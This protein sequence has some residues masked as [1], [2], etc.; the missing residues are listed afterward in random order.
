MRQYAQL[1]RPSQWTKNGFVLVGVLFGHAW[2][3]PAALGGAFVLFASFCLLSAAVYALNDVMDREADRAHPAKRLRPLPSGRVSVRGALVFGAACA[4]S[5]LLLA[6]LV[7][8]AALA[9][10]AG[11]LVLNAAYS[12]GLKHVAV[13]DVF[14]IAAGFML[15][16]L[17]GTSGIGIAP[18]RWLLLCGL[19]AT[20]FLGFAKRRAELAELRRRDPEDRGAQRRA[21]ENYS[22]ELLDRM[23]AVSA[24]GALISYALY[25]VDARTAEVQGTDQLVLTVPFVLYGLYRYLWVL[26]RRGGGADPTA[27]LLEDR[28]LLAV[29]LGWL[30]LTWWLIA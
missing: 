15:R 23:I 25:T 18:S 19:M 11:Y 26:Y 5:G 3:I 27:E 17:A 29:V 7:S 14:L 21:L 10:A 9:I 22:L 16:L 20:L 13:L 2:R 6:G 28:Q 24:A 1:A 8:L 30:A 4:G 12:L